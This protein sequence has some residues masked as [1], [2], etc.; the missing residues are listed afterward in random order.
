MDSLLVEAHSFEIDPSQVE[1]VKQRCLPNALNYPMLEE[2][3]F[4]NDNIN[5]DLEMELKPQAQPW[6]Y[7]EKSL[8]NVRIKGLDEQTVLIKR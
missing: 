8:S 5:P 1:N 4:R 2:Y 3:D 7:Q 6:P